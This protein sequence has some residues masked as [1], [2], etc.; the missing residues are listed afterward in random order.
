MG[1]TFYRLAVGAISLVTA[2]G[3]A[4]AQ[5]SASQN[6]NDGEPAVPATK[7]LKAV[8][9][10]AQR[11]EEEAQKIGIALSVL[12]GKELKDHNVQKVNDLQN[13]TPSLEVE[14]AF[15]GGQ[16]EFRLRG[17]GFSDYAS[18]NSSPVGV[19]VDGV[20]YAFPIQTQGQLFDLARVEVLRGPQ[21]TLYG[22]NTTGGAINFITNA[23]TKNLHAGVTASYGKYGELSTEAFVSGSLSSTVRGRL[24]VANDQGGAWQY[25][26]VTDQSLG[27]KRQYALRGQLDWDAS[28]I[29]NFHLN[30]HGAR[31]KSDE[32]GLYL[33]APFA[34]AGGAGPTVPADTSSR[35][36][37]WGFRPQFLQLIGQS[38]DAKPHRDNSSGGV[39][40]TANLDLDSVALTSITA[41]NRMLRRELSDWDATQYAESDEYFHSNIDV[42]SQELRLSSQDQGPWNWVTGLYYSHDT[43]DERFYSDFTNVLGGIART[44]YRQTDDT[45]GLFGQASYQFNEQWKLTLGAR[46]EHE[47]R[48]LINLSTAFLTPVYTPFITNQN[49]SQVTNEPSGKAELDFQQNADTLYYGSIS[50]GVKSGGFT[51]YNTTNPAQL[52]AFKPEVLNAYELGFKSDLSS[53]LRLNGSIFHYDYR[54]QQVLS[55]VYDPVSGGPIGRITN[56]PKSKIDGAE[57]E[58]LWRP[59]DNLEITQYLGYK[60]GKYLK[61]DTVDAQASIAAG[62]EV[63]KNFAGQPL[64]FPKLSYGGS[65]AYTWPL[66]SYQLRAETNYSYHDTYTATPLIFTPA[67]DIASYWLA[68]ANLTFKPAAGPWS[69]SLWGRNIFNRHYDLTRNFF[70]NAQVAAAGEP[71]TYGVSFSYAY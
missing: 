58:A 42:F 64:S 31:D 59:L 46:E 37:G 28:S 33:F 30:V 18:N 40:V 67:Y 52:A 6:D 38:A 12:Q 23:P 9:V 7:Q 63:T 3:M 27:T 22:R 68:N 20:A 24:S 49:R 48:D 56:A 71:V 21:G 70:I 51:A 10:T 65:V 45:V 69:V 25:N 57:L 50:R 14:P 29:L 11:R 5:T 2:A 44:S 34:T 54:N 1:N 47:S 43:L 8:V 55:T 13:A 19:S 66:G 36:T 26:R 41:W 16:P 32:Q 4:H 61:F 35:A 53:S 17:V 60:K 39:D 15:G 62:H